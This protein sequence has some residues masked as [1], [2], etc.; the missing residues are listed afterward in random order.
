V[1]EREEWKAFSP[2]RCHVLQY[3]TISIHGSRTCSLNTAIGWPDKRSYI[4]GCM[5]YKRQL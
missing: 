4:C 2:D 1:H 3:S 5:H